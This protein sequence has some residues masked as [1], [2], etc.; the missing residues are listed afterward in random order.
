MADDSELVVEFVE[1]GNVPKMLISLFKFNLEHQADLNPATSMSSDI[2]NCFSV[3]TSN[4][5]HAGML[6]DELVEFVL[7]VFIN[8]SECLEEAAD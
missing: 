4:T 1:C 3:M 7:L 2:S 8:Q 5:K 6:L